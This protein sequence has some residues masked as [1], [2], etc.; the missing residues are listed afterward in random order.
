MTTRPAKIRGRK[1]LTSF[2][3]DRYFTRVLCSLRVVVGLQRPFRRMNL[4]E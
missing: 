4:L 2:L 3:L 1:L